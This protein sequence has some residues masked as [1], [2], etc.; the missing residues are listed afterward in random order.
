[1]HAF[2]LLTPSLLAA[3]LAL[4]ALAVRG[5]LVKRLDQWSTTAV[6]EVVRRGLR[7]PSLLW[8]VVLGLYGG[9]AA[10]PLSVRT[11]DRLEIVLRALVIAL[12]AVT[13]KSVPI[14]K[15]AS[16]TPGTSSV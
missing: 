10:A 8:C 11:T 14:P 15:P 9:L 13:R 12:L 6:A 7:G 1:M 16:W 5:C 3:G 2:A 4:V